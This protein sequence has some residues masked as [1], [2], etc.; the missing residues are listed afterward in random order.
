M[1]PI[2]A[3]VC[4]HKTRIRADV[5]LNGTE[6]LHNDTLFH[7]RSLL[8][9]ENSVTSRR[10]ESVA[11]YKLPTYQAAAVVVRSYSIFSFGPLTPTFHLSPLSLPE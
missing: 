10:V 5:A 2:Q 4:A 11:K 7:H 3:P 8:D 1:P 6:L 9:E